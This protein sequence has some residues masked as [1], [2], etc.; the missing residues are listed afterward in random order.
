MGLLYIGA[1]LKKA[2]YDITLIDCLES[3][4][5]RKA[6][7]CG[8][9]HKEELEKPEVLKDIPRKYSRY[10][11]PLDEFASRLDNAPIPDAIL[12]TSIMTYWYPGVRK[13]VD[14]IKDRFKNVPILMGGIYVTLNWEHATS[15]FGSEV[16]LIKSEGEHAVLDKL[17][18]ILSFK[19]NINISIGEYDKYPYPMFD[20]YKD[21]E[22]CGMLTSRGCP[23]SC[24][25][26]ASKKLNKSFSMRKPY[27]VADEME[28]MVS[29]L[30]FKNIAFY[31]DALLYH[32]REHIIPILDEVIGRK[33]RCNFHLP[34]GIFARQVDAEVAQKMFRAGFKTIRLSFESSSA[35][36]QK[37]S[38]RKVNNDDIRQA[39]QNLYQAGYT[40]HEV[41]VYILMGLPHQPVE[42]VVESLLFARQI[43]ARPI[44]ANYA[45]IPDTP[46]YEDTKNELGIT[47]EL[48]PLLHNNSLYPLWREKYG[49]ET[50]NQ[51]KTLAKLIATTQDLNLKFMD[52]SMLGQSVRQALRK[53][54]GA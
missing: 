45:I 47:G 24:S 35:E 28:Y 31:D 18:D 13:V 9:F 37:E 12:V 39:L 36:R 19:S 30:G 7:G 41:G 21:K 46:Y 14:I 2:G 29:E 17:N 15:S 44:L 54:T 48:D 33:L 8:N 16:I 52:Q 51:V 20:A 4:D 22:Y 3:E 23:F 49:W 40:S 6:Y 25:Y 34:N 43:K 38:S 1:F 11:I 26:C 10:G 27:N 50:I 32:P 42:E 5:K 53:L